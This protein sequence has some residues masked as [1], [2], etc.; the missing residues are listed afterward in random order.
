[1]SADPELSLGLGFVGPV[2]PIRGGIAAHTASLVSTAR[3]QGVD[4]R[5]VSWASQYPRALY[6]RDERDETAAPFPG[7]EW[8]LSWNNPTSWRA[9]GHHLRGR[10]LVVAP[11]TV[12]VH[13]LHYRAI[14]SAAEAPYALVVHNV[15]PHER[16]PGSRHA[17]Q[18]IFRRASRLVVHSMTLADQCREL[19]PTVPVS[20]VPMPPLLPVVQRPLPSGPVR[21]LCLG[22]LRDYKGTDIAIRA[23]RS[24]LDRGADVSL[25]V[26]G[27]PWDGDS[28]PWTSLVRDLSL[29]GRVH[30]DLRYVG[31]EELCELIADHHMLLAPY[32]SATQSGIVSQALAAGRPV[33]ATAVGGL[34]ELV[35]DGVNGAIAP[36]DCSIGFADAVERALGSI[37]A[38][39]AA[40]VD[41]S[42][43]WSDVVDALTGSRQGAT[44]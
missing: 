41:G 25:S 11:W 4:T 36:P 30:L 23:V 9:A 31:D 34:P 29:D 10:G 27:E 18:W 44:L 33:V 15:H 42:G 43:R 19:A 26:V 28:A 20:V 39:A 17:A 8:L 16:I 7:A 1:M 32:R 35:T 40:A 24:L 2:P 37:P 3:L 14:F 13:A 6:R 22:Y 12:P 5:L 38:L 21:L